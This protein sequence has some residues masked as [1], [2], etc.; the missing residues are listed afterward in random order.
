[1]IDPN[2]PVTVPPETDG[3]SH[4]LKLVLDSVTEPEGIAPGRKPRTSLLLTKETRDKLKML[5]KEL[6]FATYNALLTSVRQ[7]NLGGG[8]PNFYLTF[9]SVSI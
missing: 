1:M 9:V 8:L 5:K 6:G 2:T 4:Y 3:V 7:G